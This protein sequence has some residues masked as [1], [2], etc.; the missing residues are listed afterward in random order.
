M[1]YQLTYKYFTMKNLY[2]IE[3]IFSLLLLITTDSFGQAGLFDYGDCPLPAWCEGEDP[4]ETEDEDGE[5]GATKA[6]DAVGE[7]SEDP[8]G[9]YGACT[10]GK[11]FFN[12]IKGAYPDCYPNCNLST[13]S[14]SSTQDNPASTSFG[15]K[16]RGGIKTFKYLTSDF[17]KTQTRPVATSFNK[18][19]MNGGFAVVTGKYIVN[20]G[21]RTE[22]RTLKIEILGRDRER[23]YD[24]MYIIYNREIAT[25][26]NKTKLMKIGGRQKRS[27]RRRG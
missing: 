7:A 17:S 13:N 6:A 16:I 27:K 8:S 21:K 24:T 10:L 23:A 14:T 4:P 22:Y 11:A 18:K 19:Y 25:I 15:L 9:C 1:D 3:A 2:F 26:V 12:L 5:N 20:K